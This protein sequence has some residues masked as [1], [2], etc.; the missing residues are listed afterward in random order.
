[1][2]KGEP[3]GLL[4]R[5]SIPLLLGNIL[6]QLYNMVDS[7]VVGQFV[8]SAALAAVG[9]GFPILFLLSSVFIGLGMGTTVM[10][11]QFVGAGDRDAV[12]RTVDTIYTALI[13][14]IV[15]LT[16]GGILL[17]RPLLVLT[18]VPA[19]AFDGALLYCVVAFGGV[20]GTLGYNLNT[21]IM[22]GLGDSRTPLL[23]LF[24]ACMLNI[25]LDLLFV[26][27]FD[28]GIFGVALAT[29]L[30]QICSWIFG[31]FYINRK[32][33]FLHIRLFQLK[34]DS[35]L[36]KQILRLGV[37]SAVHQCQFSVAILMMQALIN[38]FGTEF[39]AGFTAANKIDT[40][41]FMPIQSFTSAMAAYT[42][43]NVGA[44]RLDRVKRGLRS[45]MLL[46]TGVCIVM[47]G[48]VLVFR[49]PLLSLFNSE[50]LVVAGG[51]AYLLRAL[52]CM[53]ILAMMFTVDSVLRGAGSAVVPMISS[54]VAMWGVRIP[55]AHFLAARFGPDQLYWAYGIGWT[56]GLA[57]SL[58]AYF[59]GKWK[60]KC[61]VTRL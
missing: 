40:F 56:V 1:M 16:V 57:I 28:M 35:A 11:S 33:D 31:I 30:A 32:Y 45:A 39:A 19:E 12:R 42:G 47:S 44:G 20:I 61:V 24:I 9:T 10:I 13:V 54:M 36:L 60:E 8:G 29:I 59:R 15:P 52:S 22:Q 49:K 2:T 37:P 3:L 51:E 4:L 27:Q 41:A 58:T 23:F 48:V 50:P 17:C 7:V 46:S 5:F 43:Q 26:L 55:V 38:G 53:F 34:S 18:K 6:Q 14:V 25:V 21:G